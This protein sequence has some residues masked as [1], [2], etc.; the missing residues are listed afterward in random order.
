[1]VRV[2][3]FPR[4]HHC[5]LLN[6]LPQ[7][8]SC[9]SGDNRRAATLWST[10]R[11]TSQQGLIFVYIHPHLLCICWLCIVEVIVLEPGQRR[12]MCY[13][14]FDLPTGVIFYKGRLQ[15][16]QESRTCLGLQAKPAS[17]M[18]LELY[19]RKGLSESRGFGFGWFHCCFYYGQDCL[20]PNVAVLSH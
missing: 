1:M 18:I 15:I 12:S 5:R 4:K 11:H 10:F 20:R 8:L 16:P 7:S 6:H 13:W 14:P 3:T 2:P 9:Y 19:Q 17:P